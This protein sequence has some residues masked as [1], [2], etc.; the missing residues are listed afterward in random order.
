MTAL[1]DLALTTR[2][3]ASVARS[4]VMSGRLSG[5]EDT[6]DDLTGRRPMTVGQHIRAHANVFNGVKR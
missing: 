3:T 6:I 1:L 2:D 4:T 5:V